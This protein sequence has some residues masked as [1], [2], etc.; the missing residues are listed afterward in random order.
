[1]KRLSL[2]LAFILA[3]SSFVSN[4]QT[5]PD[6]APLPYIPGTPIII[7]PCS[8]PFVNQNTMETIVADT[9]VNNGVIRFN[10]N[11]LLNVNTV[12]ITN[13]WSGQSYS[14]LFFQP[15][16][17]VELP[18]PTQPGAYDISINTSEG[19]YTTG[20]Q[21]YSDGSIAFEMACDFIP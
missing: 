20:V 1:M 12:T 11:R 14:Y 15:T 13:R 2:V 4:A 16:F 17:V 9:Q 10:F 18:V 3:V 5:K 6:L 21:I 7:T 8:V 19:A